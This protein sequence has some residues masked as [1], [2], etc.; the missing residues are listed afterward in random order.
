MS[1]AN[2]GD[3]T[4]QRDDLATR[5]RAAGLD[6]IVPTWQAPG[7][8]HAF[9]T[10]RNATTRAGRDGRFDVGISSTSRD[11]ESVIAENRALIETFLPA[12]P[13]WL[14]QVHGSDV[15]D[16]DAVTRPWLHADASV[17]R[18]ANVVLNVRVADCMP[19]LF[20]SRDGAAVGLA[21]AGWR[22]L[23]Q[24][25]LERTLDAMRCDAH[26]IV[27]W[28][29]P[30]I[31]PTAF[32]VGAD[33]YDA[34]VGPDAQACEAFAPLRPGKWL[35]DLEALV[36]RR[37][38]YAGVTAIAGGSMCTFR[39]PARHFSYRRDGSTGRMGAFLWREAPGEASRRR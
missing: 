17:T 25:V 20:A 2:E 16:A 30:A 36:R 21:H 11:D 5:L 29:G 24:G 28:L 33:V 39:D 22:G 19:V 26:D 4:A 37:L 38:A 27:A 14:T 9:V 35:T 3:A 15:V 1:A 7:N 6:W 32:E 12:S 23:A 31:G 13:I 34:F 10:T 8:V 18:D